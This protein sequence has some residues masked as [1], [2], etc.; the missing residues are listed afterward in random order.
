MTRLN[1]KHPLYKDPLYSLFVTRF[2]HFFGL[3]QPLSKHYLRTLGHKWKVFAN[4][5]VFCAKMMYRAVKHDASKFSREES[6]IFAANITELQKHPYG[7]PEYM[8][9]KEKLGTALAH[10]YKHNDHHPEYF[11]KDPTKAM[12]LMNLMQTVEMYADWK[13]SS[14]DI[15][16]SILYNETRF[17]LD[18]QIT[19]ILL[20]TA[21]ND[22]GVKLK[23]E[24]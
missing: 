2:C 12:S 14:S 13:A 19:N 1:S 21:I 23:R 10:H 20:N 7:T 4:I 11:A 3:N 9:A 17:G 5:S 18:R 22:E 8:A 6:H 16:A 24:D 15:M